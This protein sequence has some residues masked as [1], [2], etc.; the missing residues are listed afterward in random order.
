M[1]LVVFSHKPCWRSP[2]A[3]T[4]FAT[5]GGFPFQM[6]ALARLF[7]TTTLLLPERTSVAPQGLSPLAGPGMRVVSLP[8]PRGL[9]WRRKL[10]LL[11]WFPLRLPLLWRQVQ[12]ADAVHAAVPGDI[13]TLGLLLALIQRK[14]LLVRH[15]GTWGN[16]TTL[17]DRFLAWLLP[18][19]AGGERVVLATGGGDAPPEKDFPA[20]NWIFSTSLQEEELGALR[21]AEAWRLGEPL[22]L[23]TVGRL[24]RGKNTQAAIAALPALQ[25]HHKVHLDVVGE[26]P[27]RGEL[28]ALAARLGVLPAVTF[29][30][31]VNHRQVLEIL[32]NG[33]LFV[34]PTRTAEGFPKAVLEAWACGLP[35]VAPPVSV[36]KD[37]LA[38]GRAGQL[39]ETPEAPQVAAAILKLVAQPDHLAALALQAR[40]TAQGFTLERWRD[41]IGERLAK[42]WDWQPRGIHES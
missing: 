15:C 8:E 32:Q 28:E 5:D 2:G 11:L 13:G 22:R 33:H 14:P 29:H 21:P 38:G 40:E 16:R 1:D 25:K 24:S 9:G 19:I 20:V 18:R 4:G 26:G 31:N 12:R 41:E 35:V 39:L 36:L 3:S 42:A 37:L 17:A 34:F 7:D 23:V 10:A 6:S 27:C 30:G